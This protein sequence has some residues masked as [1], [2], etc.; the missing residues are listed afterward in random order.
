MAHNLLKV[1]GIRLA[2]FLKTWNKRLSKKSI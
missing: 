2:D 1:A